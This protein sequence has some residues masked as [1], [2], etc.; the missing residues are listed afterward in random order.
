MMLSINS[1]SAVIRL[2]Q[3]G[4][5]KKKKPDIPNHDATPPPSTNKIII[6]TTSFSTKVAVSMRL[7]DKKNA[8]LPPL[9]SFAVPRTPSPPEVLCSVLPFYL[10]CLYLMHSLLLKCGFSPF[11]SPKS[12]IMC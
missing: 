7:R 11:R 5:R 1:E 2:K 12:A 6:D 10:L 8:L 9:S 4:K 3:R